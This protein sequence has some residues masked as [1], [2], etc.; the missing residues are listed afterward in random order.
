MTNQTDRKSVL[1]DFIETVWNQGNADA[2]LRFVAPLYTLRHDPGDPQDG[3]T[4]DLA[5]YAERLV[6]SRAPFPDQRF[7]ILELIADCDAIV[8][9]WRWTGTHLADLPGFPACGR[10]I[11]MTGATV[12]YF[13]GQ[14]LCGHWQIVD[15]LGVFQQL[16]PAA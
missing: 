12:Y 4:L 11:T 10:R 15:R 3:R 8:M 1:R 14:F 6:R 2:V 7:E 13:D 5:G 9:T 16:R